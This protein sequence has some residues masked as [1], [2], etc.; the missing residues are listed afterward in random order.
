MKIGAALKRM[1]IQD[2]VFINTLDTHAKSAIFSF[3]P[4]KFLDSNIGM[5]AYR[6]LFDNLNDEIYITIHGP[7]RDRLESY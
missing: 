2:K 5:K 4:K 1:E 3:L 6:K 7:L